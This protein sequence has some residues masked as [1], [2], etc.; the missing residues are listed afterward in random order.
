M[1]VCLTI[2]YP[3]EVVDRESWEVHGEPNFSDPAWLALAAEVGIRVLE[4]LGDPSA[5]LVQVTRGAG[6]QLPRPSITI[7]EIVDAVAGVYELA[8]DTLYDRGRVDVVPRQVAMYLARRLT[9]LSFPQIGRVFGRDHST[10]QHAV[11]RIEQRL[12]AEPDT[13]RHVERIEATLIARG[14]LH[15]STTQAPRRRVL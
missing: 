8:P 14:L 4:A 12:I 9:P 15:R 2:S 6:V 7:G 5:L 1:K 10:V 11:A 3:A 13:R